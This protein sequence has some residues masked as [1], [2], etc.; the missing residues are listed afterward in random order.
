MHFRKSQEIRELEFPEDFKPGLHETANLIVDAIRRDGVPIATGQFDL[1]ALSKQVDAAQFF[2][3]WVSSTNEIIENLNIVIDDMRV[4]PTMFPVLVG[5][6]ERRFYLLVATYFHEFYR[7][8]EAFISTTK[9]AVQRGYLEKKQA[10]DA[11]QSF[12]DAF[13]TA[14]KMRNVLVHRSPIWTGKRHFDLL[15]VNLAWKTGHAILDKE[16]GKVCELQDVL[17]EICQDTA[18][19]L[20][21][22]GNRMLEIQKRLLDLFVSKATMAAKPVHG[23]PK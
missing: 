17:E 2:L 16:T 23:S 20:R 21:D 13:G 3:R 19:A 11:Q 1:P 18:N 12:H 10:K 14:I 8:R 5:S 9:S 4:L 22:E 6:P 15:V 7:F